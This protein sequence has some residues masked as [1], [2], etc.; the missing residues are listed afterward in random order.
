M[1]YI[2][3]ATDLYKVG[4]RNKHVT[5][6]F[7]SMKKRAKET[8]N[9]VMLQ[10]IIRREQDKTIQLFAISLEAADLLKL[11]KEDFYDLYFRGQEINPANLFR[12]MHA[13]GMEKIIKFYG[14]SIDIIKNTNSVCQIRYSLD[15]GKES[16]YTLSIEEAKKNAFIQ[17]ELENADSLWNIE[18]KVMLLHEAMKFVAK[19][20][21]R[22]L[23]K[24]KATELLSFEKSNDDLAEEIFDKEIFDVEIEDYDYKT[25][26]LSMKNNPDSVRKYVY[27]LRCKCIHRIRESLDLCD[28]LGLP[29]D[30][31]YDI[32]ICSRYPDRNPLLN[33]RGN[34]LIDVM[35]ELGHIIQIQEATTKSCVLRFE[36]DGIERME[37]VVLENIKRA[38][39]SISRELENPESIWSKH[40][41]IMLLYQGLHKIIKSDFS[42]I[43]P[44][45]EKISMK[46]LRNLLFNKKTVTNEEIKGMKEIE[47]EPLDEGIVKEE[48]TQPTTMTKVEM[49]ETLEKLK[50]L[51]EMLNNKK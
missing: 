32:A 44:Q 1:E 39:E 30:L 49:K 35:R 28:T 10:Q 9:S 34:C 12:G 48:T 21:F 36:K 47:E 13:E 16:T 50:K 14:Y 11:P 22:R 42:N 18:P 25:T 8:N 19:T 31:F 40:P 41:T 23:F 17:E 20:S 29:K 43:K 6:Y 2:K 26:I 3:K 51:Q 27:E 7:A 24:V 4:K 46:N 45:N 38:K 15:E 33:V 37:Q 5:S